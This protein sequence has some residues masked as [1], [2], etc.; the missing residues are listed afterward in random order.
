MK[1]VALV[2]SAETYGTEALGAVIAQVMESADLTS[3]VIAD[4]VTVGDLG[5]FF[6][7]PGI[8]QGVLGAFKD[9]PK[10]AFNLTIEEELTLHKMIDDKLVELSAD[11]EPDVLEPIAAGLLKLLLTA[12][13]LGV[14]GRD[15]V[16]ALIESFNPALDQ[17]A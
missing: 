10:E 2:L 15:Y 9:L 6:R 3:D 17:A 4:G 12:V 7:I 14:N 16:V 8:Y 11:V 13:R 5:Q 1:S